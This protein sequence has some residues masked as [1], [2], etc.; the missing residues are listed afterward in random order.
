MKSIFIKILLG[1]NFM[2]WPVLRFDIRL[3]DGE[4]LAISG[5]PIPWYSSSVMGTGDINISVVIFLVDFFIILGTI[6]I[7]SK[8]LLTQQLENNSTKKIVSILLF[9][10]I[11]PPLLALASKVIFGDWSGFVFLPWDGWN[12]KIESVYLSHGL[13]SFNPV[14]K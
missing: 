9:I 13:A 10:L 6:E 1:L 11:F 12:W 14:A 8:F 2:L 5:F 7:V 3:P 4:S